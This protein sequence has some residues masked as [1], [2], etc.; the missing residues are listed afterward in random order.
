MVL[1]A[2]TK[3]TDTLLIYTF[4]LGTHVVTL[5]ATDEA[6]NIGSDSVTIM[7]VNTTPSEINAIATPSTLWSPNHKYVEV[8]ATVTA[9]DICDPLTD[10]HVGIHHGQ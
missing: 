4:N 3:V 7:V 6:G 9:Y 5:N 8:K 1:K 2:V 10:N